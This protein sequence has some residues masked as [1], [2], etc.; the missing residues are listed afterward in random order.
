[1][2][3]FVEG[4]LESRDEPVVLRAGGIGYE[5]HVPERHRLRLPS[6]GETVRLYTHLHLREDEM[7]LYGFPSTAEREIFRALI[8]V[9]GV[10]PKV[11][12]AVLGDAQADAVLRGIRRG[13]A[14]PLVA[15]RGI[16]KKTAERVVLELEEKAAAWLPAEDGRVREPNLPTDLPEQVHEAVLALEALGVAPERARDAVVSL[17]AGPGVE[18]A[19]LV[20]AALRHLHPSR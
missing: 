13:D 8:S 10:G 20:R 17:P 12:L 9:K 7:T 1:M 16:G 3:A 6:P 2:Y 4:S 11:A 15:I 14:R 18:V 5:L 19:D